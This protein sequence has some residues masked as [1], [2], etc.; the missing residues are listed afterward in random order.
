MESLLIIERRS[1]GGLSPP[2]GQPEHAYLWEHGAMQDLSPSGTSGV[3]MGINNRGQVVGQLV[4]ADNCSY[5]FIWAAGEMTNLNALLVGSTPFHGYART[6]N[7]RGQIL[8]DVFQD[9]VGCGPH[10]IELPV[11]LNPI[12]QREETNVP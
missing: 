2:L 9:E 11:V 5:P 10:Q 4:L 7:D 3:A 12:R 1:S 6:I 8:G